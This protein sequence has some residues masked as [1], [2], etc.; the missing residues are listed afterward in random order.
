M[1]VS[2]FGSHGPS[3]KSNAGAGK[4]SAFPQYDIAGAEPATT[5]SS[6]RL[7]ARKLLAILLNARGAQACEPVLVDGILPGE[8]LFDGQRV[9]AAG[10]FERQQTAAHG[11]NNLGLAPDNPAFRA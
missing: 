11:G 4:S 2:W 6:V 3:L 1:R 7:L 8:E 10:F 5:K 9:A